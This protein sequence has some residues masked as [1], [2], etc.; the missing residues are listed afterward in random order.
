[1]YDKLHEMRMS[2]L[3][4]KTIG[5]VL[6]APDWNQLNS[7]WTKLKLP[8]N[9]FGKF[10]NSREIVEL[11]DPNFIQKL[12][13]SGTKIERSF[14]IFKHKIKIWNTNAGKKLELKT[15]RSITLLLCI[16]SESL[17]NWTGR[18]HISSH[19]PNRQKYHPNCKYVDVRLIF[20]GVRCY[21]VC[22]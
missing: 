22:V 18:I 8:P 17:D 16:L 15:K 21:N 5:Q 9:W 14:H 4:S 12:L 19:F 3:D 10:M 11:L 20:S 1:M 6:K 13:P 2:G 7:H